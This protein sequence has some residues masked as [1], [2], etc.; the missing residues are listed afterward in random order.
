MIHVCNRDIEVHL[1]PAG[2]EGFSPVHV[3][4]FRVVEPAAEVRSSEGMRVNIVA[5]TSSAQRSVSWKW[6]SRVNAAT[7][8]PMD[9]SSC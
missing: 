5:G 4:G 6:C 9:C 3:S 2:M 8:M 1:V 7:I